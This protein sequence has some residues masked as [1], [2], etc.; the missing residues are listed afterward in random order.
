MTKVSREALQP[1]CSWPQSRWEESALRVYGDVHGEWENS[2]RSICLWTGP[3]WVGEA[4]RVH[5]HNQ[6][7]KR[8]HSVFIA[9]VIVVSGGISLRSICSWTGPRWV[10][11]ALRVHCHNQGEKRVHYVFIALVM[12]VSGGSS[13]LSIC[14]WTGPRWVGEALRVHCHNQGEKRVHSVFMTMV[15]VS[16]KLSMFSVF[17]NRARVSRE[18]S[19]C[20]C[21]QSRWEEGALHVYD[22]G[23][24]EWKTLYVLHVHEQGQCE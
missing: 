20:S 17:M 10:G 7:E 4:L 5:C 16:G 18:S 19:P 23:H 2:L 3:R 1:P 24:G 13:L 12:V 9:L 14:S 6:G 11:E 22:L 21:P 8:V 15:M